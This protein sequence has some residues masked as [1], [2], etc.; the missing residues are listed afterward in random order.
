MFGF[1]G[2]ALGSSRPLVSNVKRPFTEEKRAGT[3]D[4]SL[5]AILRTYLA[6]PGT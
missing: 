2:G 4:F 5:A 1:R 3:L 6:G